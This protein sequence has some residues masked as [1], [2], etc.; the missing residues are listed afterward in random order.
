MSMICRN[1]IKVFDKGDMINYIAPKII[2]ACE[3]FATKLI[4]PSEKLVTVDYKRTIFSYTVLGKDPVQIISVNVDDSVHDGC[5]VISIPIV[6]NSMDEKFYI[7]IF[8][9]HVEKDNGET[10]WFFTKIFTHTE[11]G[12]EPISA[13]DINVPV[14][15]LQRDVIM[16]L[17]DLNSKINMALRDLEIIM[18]D[19]VEV[20]ADDVEEEVDDNEDHVSG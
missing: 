10:E 11:Y 13:H 5:I 9:D 3:D 8:P 14:L 20:C 4:P 17:I 19:R 15:F 18:C 16:G 12:D 2:G 1:R 6:T 7:R